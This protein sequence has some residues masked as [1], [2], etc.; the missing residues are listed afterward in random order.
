MNTLTLHFCACGH[1]T[2]Y[3]RTEYADNAAGLTYSGRC[4][5]LDETTG[6]P[7]TCEHY[8]PGET[9]RAR[10]EAAQPLTAGAPASA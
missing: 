9:R 8:V 10:L 5:D 2:I 6:Q 7:C 3:H 1:E 4:T